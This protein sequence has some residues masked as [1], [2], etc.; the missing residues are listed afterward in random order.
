MFTKSIQNRSLGMDIP[1]AREQ[2]L[3]LLFRDLEKTN[4]SIIKIMSDLPILESFDQKVNLREALATRYL[5]YALSTI[6]NRAL[7]DVRDSFF[8]ESIPE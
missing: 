6:T 1:K 8:L 4:L 3:N 7:P 5:A 2:M